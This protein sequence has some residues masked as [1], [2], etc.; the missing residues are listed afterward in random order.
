MAGHP[1]STLWRASRRRC[2]IPGPVP[3]ATIGS[4][5]DEIL[6]RVR[7]RERSTRRRRRALAIALADHPPRPHGNFCGVHRGPPRPARGSGSDAGAAVDSRSRDGSSTRLAGLGAGGDGAPGTGRR[8]G[9]LCL[10]KGGCRMRRRVGSGLEPCSGS[11]RTPG[12]TRLCSS[13]GLGPSQASPLASR[14]LRGTAP[15]D[16]GGAFRDPASG[17]LC[18]RNRGRTSARG[19]RAHGRVGPGGRRGVS[20]G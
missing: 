15:Q 5:G 17:S 10:P 14:P 7:N 12:R 19:R 1:V 2:P 18:L 3:R 20:I 4:E 11:S 16:M 8:P 9:S 13:R 6:R